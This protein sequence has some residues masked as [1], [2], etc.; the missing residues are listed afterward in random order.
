MGICAASAIV[1]K[2]ILDVH[3]C[4]RRKPPAEIGIVF[5]FTLGLG[6]RQILRLKLRQR[7]V[8]TSGAFQ[9]DLDN[10]AASM[11]SLAGV[12]LVL[13]AKMTTRGQ[14]AQKVGSGLLAN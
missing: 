11:R 6:R 4:A 2:C 8:G 5:Y 7:M 14:A 12:V 13:P 1:T 3:V 10:L 9:S